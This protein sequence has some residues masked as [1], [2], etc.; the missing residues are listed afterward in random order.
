MGKRVPAYYEKGGSSSLMSDLSK[1]Q[2]VLDVVIE[3]S[4]DG[5]YITDGHA[6][7]LMVNQS[8]EIIS[9]LKREQVLGK[10]MK[11]LVQHDIIDQSGTL[12]AIKTREPITIEQEFQTGKRAI[13]TSTPT[14]DE[15]GEVVMVITNVRDVT[16]LYELKN[17]L[18]QNEKLSEKNA[19]ELEAIRREMMGDGAITVQD[20]AMLSVLHM[21]QRVCKMDTTVLLTGET[22]V[23]KDQ[24]AS[25][26]FRH[27]KRAEERFIKVNC[28]AIPPSLIESELFGYARGAFTGANKEGKMGLF[29]VADKG[30]IFLDEVGELPPDMQVKLLRV[31][32]EQEIERIGSN[33]PIKVD[34][35]VIAA[36]N[37]NLQEMLKEKTFRADL[38]YRLNVFPV[39]IPPLRERREDIV[40]LAE[41]FLE[42]LN[43]KY[44]MNKT[45]TAAAREALIK[46]RW[47]GNVRELKN[48]VE[49]AMIMSNTAEIT[50]GN[51]FLH[52]ASAAAQPE[53][54]AQGLDLR[55][56]VERIELDYI[57]NAYEHWGN[58]REAAKS[59]GMD[60]ATFVRKRK[61]YREK[62]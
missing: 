29:E 26:I 51:L 31:L 49:R 3:G 48:V 21:I 42:E 5:I 34:V 60:A 56:L 43:H 23:G 37:R 39:L 1:A 52:V 16:E 62:Y 25:Y 28:G 41:Q 15:T 53:A 46:Y 10:N 17:K 24:V 59:L 9:G 47:P 19:S 58:V 32:Q 36:T 61:K 18:R 55:S 20:P 30:T 33:K 27:S 4:Y 8:Y 35:R 40:P 54:D 13:I 22:G 57:N 2:S 14:L 44:G 45:L 38:Y 7:T 50:V 6:N 12:M 11:D